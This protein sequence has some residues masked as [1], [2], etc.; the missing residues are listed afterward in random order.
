MN[1]GQ[2]FRMAGAQV[3]SLGVCACEGIL[4]STV[5]CGTSL[6]LTWEGTWVRSQPT[7]A[8]AG[9]DFSL[10]QCYKQPLLTCDLEGNPRESNFNYKSEKE[11]V[12]MDCL[13]E[14]QK[15]YSST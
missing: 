15:M 13:R 11:L 3:F 8:E 4:L 1:S 5:P 2:C 6:S 12:L 9:T 7:L 14:R 10:G